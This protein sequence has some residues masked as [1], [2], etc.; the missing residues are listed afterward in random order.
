M[1]LEKIRKNCEENF[2]KCSQVRV[3]IHVHVFL[4]GLGFLRQ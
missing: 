2:K 4:E 1:A 3:C